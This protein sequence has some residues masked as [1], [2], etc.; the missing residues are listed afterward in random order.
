MARAN[1]YDPKNTTVTSV[2]YVTPT[3]TATGIQI[4]YPLANQTTLLEINP[5]AVTAQ[6]GTLNSW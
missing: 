3:S 2:Q 6:A 5:K 1:P 4:A